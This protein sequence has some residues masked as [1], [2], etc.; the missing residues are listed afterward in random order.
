MLNP[1]PTSGGASVSCP[2]PIAI[3]GVEWAI[4]PGKAIST[5][6]SI[7]RGGSSCRLPWSDPRTRVL[8][9]WLLQLRPDQVAEFP[10][11]RVAR[12]QCGEAD[13]PTRRGKSC[14]R[15][16]SPHRRQMEG[17]KKS[18]GPPFRSPKFQSPTSRTV[19]YNQPLS[20]AEEKYQRRPRRIARGISP[21]AA[22]AAKSCHETTAESPS[23]A[24]VCRLGS[25]LPT[26]T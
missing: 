26:H 10:F 17:A 2:S 15:D 6:P 22:M 12:R 14:Q 18:N 3:A 21:M 1:F 8:R 13:N 23:S 19:P 25:E 16:G 7:L 9:V 24:I 11:A 5:R 20:P 4:S